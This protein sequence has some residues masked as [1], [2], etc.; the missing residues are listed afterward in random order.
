MIARTLETASKPRSHGVIRRAT[1]WLLFVPVLASA[2]GETQLPAATVPSQSSRA[3]AP[4]PD[5]APDPAHPTQQRDTVE[6]GAPLENAELVTI[7]D[8]VA[9]PSQ[10]ENKA[11]NVAG[12]FLTNFE[13]SSLVEPGTNRSIPVKIRE[14]LKATNVPLAECEGPVL[15]SGFV[16]TLHSG[17][18]IIDARAMLRKNA[19]RP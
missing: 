1:L 19:S 13:Y 17:W 16:R 14:L 2:C 3:G 10:Y 9:R 18:P 15:I 6:I 11:V 12:I 8:L 7:A 4:P 5:P